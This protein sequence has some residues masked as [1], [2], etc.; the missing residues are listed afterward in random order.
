MH[1]PCTKKTIP[2]GFGVFG[3]QLAFHLSSSCTICLCLIIA[4]ML[5]K[6]WLALLSSVKKD[7]L[8]PELVLMQTCSSYHMSSD[9]RDSGCW[10]KW[11]WSWE[12]FCLFPVLCK[13][14]EAFMYTHIID[15]FAISVLPSCPFWSIYLHEPWQRWSL[16]P[17]L[18]VSYCYE[19]DRWKCSPEHFICIF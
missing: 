15:M 9:A 8:A 2:E 6:P 3:F 19:Q 17:S 14:C 12:L 11:G 13:S 18:P 16:V 7:K 5:K 4:I 10:S 1:V